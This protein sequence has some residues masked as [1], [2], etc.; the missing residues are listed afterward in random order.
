MTMGGG[1]LSETSTT[2]METPAG[3]KSPGPG[4]TLEADGERKASMI[5]VE[6]RHNDRVRHDVT[7]TSEVLTTKM[8]PEWGDVT[9]AVVAGRVKSGPVLVESQTGQSDN[10]TTTDDPAWRLGFSANEGKH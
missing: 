3:K 6:K 4:K 1:D 7:V 9:E 8:D 5:K 10:R 2:K